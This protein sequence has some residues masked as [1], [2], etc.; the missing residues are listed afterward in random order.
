MRLPR[1]PVYK[2][3]GVAWL[4]QV[5]THWT[6]APLKW[7][8]DIQNGADHKAVEV[9]SGVPVIG[10][11]GPFAFASRAMYSG[12]AVLLGRKG[13]IDRPLHVK[14]EFWTVDT[15][16]WSK[17]Q[18]GACGR[19]AYYV[20]TVIPFGYYSTSTALPSM[21][22]SA[23]NAHL[24]A[25]PEQEEQRAIATFLDRETAKIDALIAEQERLIALLAEKRQATISHAVTRGLNP[26]APMRDSGVPWLGDVPA[27]W[28]VQRIG[29]LF[30]EVNQPGN[31]TLPLLSVSI[32][33]GVSDRELDDVELDRK[34]TRSEDRS[35]YK[36]VQPGDLTYN[37]MRAWQG[38][39]GAVSVEGMVSPAYVVAR[40]VCEVLASHVD[41][42]LRTPNAVAEMKRHSRGVTD[43]RLRL[44][45][46]EFKTIQL[47][48]PPIGEQEL[49]ADFISREER[50]CAG[51]RA[52]VEGGVELLRER[53][54]A[55]IAAAVT[56][57]IDV[58]GLVP[59][60]LAPT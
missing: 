36:A 10:S 12:E 6:V 45:W 49:I 24:V 38:G 18:P 23:L 55:L 59:Q 21:T 28:P 53:R 16:Y 37:M 42:L 7:L 11:G 9:E 52:E 2:Q 34:V 26:N 22:K 4:G 29:A 5:P 20:A 46:D 41:A 58:R 14:G 33:D 32:H 17:I 47:A 57:Q 54:S 13:T 43:F 1:Y 31:D 8:L 25:C 39:F 50:K 44:Y 19:F 48:L 35:K 60:D 30:R 27:H 15:M 51:L 56:G 3:T 40:P